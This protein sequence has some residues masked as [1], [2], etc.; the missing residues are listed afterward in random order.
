MVGPDMAPG[1]P[2]MLEPTVLHLATLDPQ[3]LC[4]DTHTG[5]APV[6]GLGKDTCIEGVF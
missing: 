2:G 1:C 6:Y 5:G 4:A 3:E